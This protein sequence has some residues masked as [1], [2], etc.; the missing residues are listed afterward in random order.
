MVANKM[1]LSWKRGF[2][3]EDQKIRQLEKRLRDAELEGDILEKAVAIFSKAP[4]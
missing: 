4:K 1:A 3:Q 2:S